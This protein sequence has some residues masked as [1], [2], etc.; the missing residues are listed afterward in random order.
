MRFLRGKRKADEA[1]E[2][3]CAICREPLPE[4]ATECNMCG[5]PALRIAPRPAAKRDSNA[6]GRMHIR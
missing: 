6:D 2:S 5:A 1:L 3:R 4:D